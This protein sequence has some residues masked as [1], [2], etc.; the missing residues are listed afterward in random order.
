MKI[1]NIL[2]FAGLCLALVL[3]DEEVMSEIVVESHKTQD[4]LFDRLPTK[5]QSVSHFERTFSKL[6]DTSKSALDE[7]VDVASKTGE[8]VPDGDHETAL[9]AQSWLESAAACF[10]DLG[11]HGDHGHHGRY[12]PNLTVYELISK[13]KYTTKLAALINEYEDI[14]TL[15]NG[16]AANYT[17]FAPTDK[18]FEKIPEHAPKPSKEQLKEILLYHVSPDFYPAGR[19]LVTRTVP[20]LLVGEE[21]G[22]EAQR[23]S[24]NISPKG[25]T[26]NFYSRIIAI[27]IVSVTHFPFNFCG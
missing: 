27:D 7:A 12:K 9:F 11:K 22:G 8:Q 14:V 15:L 2:P 19:V 13:S 5:D 24:T 21:I 25:L 23:L 6:V 4:S 1:F 26:V 18:A 3:P 10:E 20:T 16:T 17:I